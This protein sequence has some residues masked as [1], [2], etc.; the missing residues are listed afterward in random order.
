MLNF[1]CSSG[2]GDVRLMQSEPIKVDKIAKPSL[3]SMQ[4]SMKRRRHTNGTNTNL[5]ERPPVSELVRNN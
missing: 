5:V 2:A 4:N 3:R 1:K